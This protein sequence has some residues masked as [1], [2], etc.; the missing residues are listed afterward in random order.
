M[1]LRLRD[2][3]GRAVQRGYTLDEVREC[4][5]RDYG[6]G[7]L[8]VDVQHAAYPRLA[9]DGHTQ[10]K[11]LGDV[12]QSLLAGMG[13]TEAAVSAVTGKPCRCGERKRAL[14]DLGAKYLGLPPGLP[15]ENQG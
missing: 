10:P 6:N 11:G 5:V 9:R 13:I 7:W 4:I 1:R 2:L 15:P 3:L 12:V 8:D 14:N